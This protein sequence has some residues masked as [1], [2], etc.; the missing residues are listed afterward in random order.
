[1][2]ERPCTH[3]GDF[4]GILQVDSYGGYAALAKLRQEVQLA[5]CW[6]HVGGKFYEL[7]A[8]YSVAT[9]VL[10]RIADLYAVDDRA[11][12]QSAEKRRTLRSEHSR[13]IVDDLKQYLEARNRQVSATSKL[14][15]AIRYALLRWD[16][17]TLI[18]DDGR[19]DLDNDTV[20]R[21]IRPLTLNRKNALFAG[22][23]EGGDN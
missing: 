2:A 9:E 19:F 8:N 5:F 18:I 7:A 23:D 22:S 14:G 11:R 16:G 12:G 6:A 13:P 10:R 3:L 17:L 15:E 1:M 4:A 21:A 20:E